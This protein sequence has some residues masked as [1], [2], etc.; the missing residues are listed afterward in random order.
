M[1]S[2]HE[3]EYRRTKFNLEANPPKHIISRFWHPASTIERANDA[4]GIDSSQISCFKKKPFRQDFDERYHTKLTMKSFL[5]LSIWASCFAG[6]A[7]FAGVNSR[8]GLSP[9][10]SSLTVLQASGKGFGAA[11]EPPKKKKAAAPS[12]ST[13]ST[14]NEADKVVASAVQQSPPPPTAPAPAPVNAGQRALAEMRR[15]RAEEKDAELQKVREMLEADRQVEQQAAAI[16]ERVAQRMGK[17]MLPFVGLP[18][19]GGMGCFVAFWYL[20]TY[21][22][23]EFQPALV[24]GSTIA[25]LVVSLLVRCSRLP[26]CER[27]ARQD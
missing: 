8:L 10:P 4:S 14:S 21:K 16:P 3:P 9:Q 27:V 15:Q 25:I 12:E 1:R 13:T 22:D 23:M 5:T 19:L 2:G 7:S 6:V 17:R 26:S 18:L 24:A 20:A 11:P